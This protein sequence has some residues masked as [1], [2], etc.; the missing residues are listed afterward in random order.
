MN[1]PVIAKAMLDVPHPTVSETPVKPGQEITIAPKAEAAAGKAV[2][3][4]IAARL[5]PRL[6]SRLT[7]RLHGALLQ[8]LLPLLG[9]AAF[10]GVWSVIAQAS[11]NLPGPE[12]TWDSA[13]ELFSSPFYRNGP[14]DQGI[15]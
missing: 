6:I 12:R 5:N 8:V 3:G 13:M 4:P 7:P 10:I 9:L 15:G 2:S 1:S 11:P 14:N